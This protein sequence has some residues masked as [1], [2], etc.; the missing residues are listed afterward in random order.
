MFVRIALVLMFGLFHVAG[1]A[2]ASFLDSDFF[3]RV[4]GCVVVHDGLTFNVYDVHDFETNGTVP[5]GGE[6]IPWTGNPFQGTGEVRPVF[7]GTIT[8][9]VH[10]IPSA[11]EGVQVGFSEGA[12]GDISF[13]SGSNQNGFLDASTTFNSFSLSES[14][15]LRALDSSIQRSLYIS[16]RTEGFRISAASTLTGSRDA[17]NQVST[18]SN[19][20]FDYGITLRGNDS[21]LVFGNTATD[22]GY[23]R[24]GNFTT[25]SPLVNAPQ[26]IAE[27]PNPIRSGFDNS[28]PA[29]SIRFDY[30]YGFEKYDLSLGAGNL[31]Y[32]IEFSFFRD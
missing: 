31:Q 21:G 13:G 20:V 28:L 1:Q 9:G 27:F 19:V 3:C 5:P 25:L 2:H 22:G 32:Q 15:Q 4:K 26:F 8:E 12:N 30:I 6:L 18:L 29:Q 16:S 24:L 14:T 11:S 23:R 17:L 10:I 7:T